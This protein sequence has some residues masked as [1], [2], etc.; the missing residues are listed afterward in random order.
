PFRAGQEV[1]A[2]DAVQLINRKDA[3][4]IDVRDV[5]E[6]EAGHIAGARHVPERQLA[7]RLKEL[8][9]FRD[10]PMIVTC[11]S[12]TRSGVAVQVLRRNG[13]NEAVNLRGGIGAWEQAGMPLKR[14]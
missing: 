2:F 14:K 8:E 3:V 13:F 5:G 6:Y 9:K 12:G 4:V 11:R 7:E 1:G 10:R